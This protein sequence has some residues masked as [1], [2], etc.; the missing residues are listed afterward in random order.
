MSSSHYSFI[1]YI[2]SV[3]SCCGHV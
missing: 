1:L 3:N 2:M